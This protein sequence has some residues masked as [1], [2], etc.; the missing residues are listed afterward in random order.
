MCVLFILVNTRFLT[1]IIVSTKNNFFDCKLIKKYQNSMSIFCMSLKVKKI[2]N[3][4]K[5]TFK[6]YLRNLRIKKNNMNYFFPNNLLLVLLF[7]YHVHDN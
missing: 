5:I 1:I 4:V 6:I 7:S 3:T 2:I